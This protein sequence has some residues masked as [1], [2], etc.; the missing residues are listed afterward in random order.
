VI[1]ANVVNFLA[2]GNRPRHRQIVLAEESTDALKITA[3]PPI[4]KLGKRQQEQHNRE[5]VGGEPS[6][7]PA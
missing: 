7:Q 3:G 6:A 4:A 2:C 1:E 5:W